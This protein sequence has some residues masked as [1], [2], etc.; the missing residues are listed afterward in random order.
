MPGPL[1]IRPSPLLPSGAV[2]TDAVERDLRPLGDLML[3]R[4]EVGALPTVRLR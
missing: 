2:L 1:R 3:R 4:A